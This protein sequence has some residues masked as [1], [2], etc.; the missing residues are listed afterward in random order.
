[1]R[2]EFNFN[3]IQSVEFCVN[4]HTNGHEDANYLVPIDQTVQDALKQV[5]EATLAAI[6]P[7]DGW[8]PYE[9]SEKYASKESLRADLASDAMTSIRALHEEEGWPVRVGALSDPKK[10]AYYFAVF[11]DNR[12]RRLTAVRQATQFKGA[13]KGRFVSVIDDTLRLIPDRVFKLDD[14]FDF[15]ITGQHIY[16]LH[17]AGF[18]RIAEIEEFAAVKARTMMLSLGRK[19]TFIECAGLADYVAKRRRAARL[20]AALHSRTDLHTIK[21]ALFVKAAKDTGVVLVAVGRKLAPAAGSELGILEMLDDRRYTTALKPGQ[22]PA[23]VASSR[24][25]LCP[26]DTHAGPMRGRT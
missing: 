15:L 17:P 8:A 5:L 11:R 20:V 19:V 16:I 14:Q 1:M 18:E 25:R 3:H 10:I 12:G 6:E 26:D 9:L 4:V 2:N 7:E 13:F 23:F 21:R 24:R 22:K